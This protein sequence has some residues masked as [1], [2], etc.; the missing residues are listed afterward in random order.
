[1]LEEREVILSID[2]TLNGSPRRLCGVNRIQKQNGNGNSA[3]ITYDDKCCRS[4]GHCCDECKFQIRTIEDFKRKIC[5]DKTQK[6]RNTY[7]ESLFGH[8]SYK[9][10]KS[11]KDID[12]LIKFIMELSEEDYQSK[13]KVYKEQL[14]NDEF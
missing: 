3:Y 14:E 12:N 4:S 6:S 11:L 7:H 5:F 13:L 8:F 2:V 10:V 1:M 9:Y